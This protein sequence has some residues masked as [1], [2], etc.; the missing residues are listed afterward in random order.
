MRSFAHIRA[1]FLA[2][3]VLVALASSRAPAPATPGYVFT[4]ATGADGV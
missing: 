4:I 2:V 3:A 1:A